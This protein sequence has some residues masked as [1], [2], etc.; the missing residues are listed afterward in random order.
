LITSALKD[1]E[2]LTDTVEEGPRYIFKDLESSDHEHV[3][4]PLPSKCITIAQ[5]KVGEDTLVAA[6]S[7]G[8]SNCAEILLPSLVKLA[9]SSC[10]TG[11]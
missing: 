4:P 10:G 11:S 8:V 6:L 3:A 1:I 7:V 5:M 9:E 2:L